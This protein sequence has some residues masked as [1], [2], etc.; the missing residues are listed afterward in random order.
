MN[1]ELPKVLHA[2]CGRPMLAYA[3]DACGEAGIEQ[4]YVVVGH[5]QEL[6]REAFAERDDITWIE[7]SEQRGTGHA[8]M[9]CREAMKDFDGSVVVI[10]GDMPLVRRATVA[11]ILEARADSGD[12]VVMGTSVLDDP[13]GYGRII[14]NEHGSLEG[15]VEDRDCTPE[16][17]KI[18]EV[19]PSYYCFDARRMFETLDQVKPNNAKGEYYITDVVHLLRTAGAG[20]SAHSAVPREEALGI[21]S[22]V[23]LAEVAR[24]MQDRLQ[25]ELMDAGVT[26]IDPDNTWIE[27]GVTIGRDTVVYPFSYIGRGCA[28]G[29]NCRV[30]PFANLEPGEKVESGTRVGGPTNGVPV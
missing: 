4:L 25:A 16:Q 27:C 18:R 30:G 19:N 1:S 6:V 28:I 8:V 29:E 10:A 15:I 12:A 7:Q 20:V 22:R 5:K 26:I 9:C 11:A 3:L 23:D 13:T 14:R 2:I 24:T 21:N 17:R